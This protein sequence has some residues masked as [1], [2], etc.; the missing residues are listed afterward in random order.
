MFYL[1]CLNCDPTV[2]LCDLAAPCAPGL[3]GVF[4]FTGKLSIPG[5][6]IIKLKFLLSKIGLLKTNYR[7]L[8]ISEI[9]LNL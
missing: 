2:F 9:L 7:S 5:I 1:G 3:T 6:M 8:Q 4:F